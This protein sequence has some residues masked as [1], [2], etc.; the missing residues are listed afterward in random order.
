MGIKGEEVCIRGRERREERKGERE[1]ECV[2]E[3][4]N[5]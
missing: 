5:E 3:T 4:E 1:K 2:T